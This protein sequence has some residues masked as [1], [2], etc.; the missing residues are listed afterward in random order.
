M[1][2]PDL[3]KEDMAGAAGAIAALTYAIQNGDNIV[4]L[5]AVIGVTLIAMTIIAAGA[6]RRGKRADNLD[7]IMDANEDTKLVIEDN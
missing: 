2:T 3:T 5:A 4:T 7:A 6:Y 1:N